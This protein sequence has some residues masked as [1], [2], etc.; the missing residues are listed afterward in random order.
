MSARVT[1]TLAYPVT[2]TKAGHPETL[3]EVHVRRMRLEDEIAIDGLSDVKTAH[4]L[5]SRLCD[6]D[7]AIAATLDSAD[8]EAIGS[9]IQGFQTAGQPIGATVSA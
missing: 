9:I 7:A 2:Y 8:C 5:I 6:I 4:V 3:N 1:H